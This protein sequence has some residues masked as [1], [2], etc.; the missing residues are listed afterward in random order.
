M[1]QNHFVKWFN[2]MIFQFTKLLYKCFY[3]K[4]F[5]TFFKL[6]TGCKIQYINEIIVKLLQR[7]QILIYY[8]FGKVIEIIFEIS[9]QYLWARI[10]K[11]N[12]IWWLRVSILLN[13]P[14]GHV[15][16]YRSS[17]EMWPIIIWYKGSIIA[18]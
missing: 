2:Q 6:Y 3:V 5:L 18:W 8:N 10:L 16:S 9:F 14:P 7:N 11:Y 15:N 12:G 13:I 4:S 1:S 17:R